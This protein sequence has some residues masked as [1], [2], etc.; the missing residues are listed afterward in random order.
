[1][2]ALD[3]YV[4][5]VTPFSML[6]KRVTLKWWLLLIWLLSFSSALPP[7]IISHITHIRNPCDESEILRTLCYQDLRYHY[8]VDLFT[9][10]TSY[11]VPLIC[12]TVCY[13][14]ITRRLIESTRV[15]S[16][17]TVL[18]QTHSAR[19]QKVIRVLVAV[20]CIFL[21]C[22]L[23]LRLYQ[24]VKFIYPNILTSPLVP[25]FYLAAYWL[26]VSNSTWN[27]II[28][29]F[30]FIKNKKE[31]QAAQTLAANDATALISRNKKG[32]NNI[33]DN[34]KNV[35]SNVNHSMTCNGTKGIISG[36]P[37]EMNR[38]MTLTTPIKVNSKSDADN[39]GR[40]GKVSMTAA[41]NIGEES[42]FAEPA[43]DS[44]FQR[45]S[46][47]DQDNENGEEHFVKIQKDVLESISEKNGIELKQD[48]CE[49]S[50]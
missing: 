1:M 7:T 49:S 31:N 15:V 14:A 9:L 41:S 44:I 35:T 22:W 23:P 6:F 29:S 38:K 18:G 11:V 37:S 3:R 2:I 47:K 16:N 4:A 21:L 19:N 27:P 40:D 32:G 34:S 30:Y 43:K 36:V 50:L 25:K 48:N 33:H 13:A 5:V 42:T 17:T 24:L 12:M 45:L 39:S 28:Y 10:V 26:G 46:E 20:V 8:Y